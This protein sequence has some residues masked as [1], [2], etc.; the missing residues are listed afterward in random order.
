MT[1]Y[2]R[3][4]ET[5]GTIAIKSGQML[6]AA[7]SS[8]WELLIALEQDCRALATELKR[9]EPGLAHPDAEHL[10]RKAELIQKVLADDAAIRAFTEPWMCQ[11]AAYLGS[12]RQ[13]SRLQR[14]YNC[15]NGN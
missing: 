7:R 2:K 8:D 14:A 10:R 1:E 9:V 6:D 3:I 5:Y 12:A 11:L 4:L 13:E 15:N